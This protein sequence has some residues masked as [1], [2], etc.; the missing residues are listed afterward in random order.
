MQSEIDDIRTACMVLEFLN[1]SF[2]GLTRED[3]TDGIRCI[4][5]NLDLIEAQQGDRLPPG[6]VPL[7]VMTLAQVA[8]A[9]ARERRRGLSVIEGGRHG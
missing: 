6:D 7:P 8:A 1:A 5:E 4:R 3:I 9:A 2:G